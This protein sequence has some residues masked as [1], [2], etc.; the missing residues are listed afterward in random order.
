MG[1]LVCA[2]LLTLVVPKFQNLLSDFTGAQ[3]TLPW[4]TEAIFALSA[5]MQSSIGWLSL[6]AILALGLYLFKKQSSAIRIKAALLKIP[7]IGRLEH[8][9]SS[10]VLL[11]SLSLLLSNTIPIQS[12]LS[13]LERAFEKHRLGPTIK[14]LKASVNEGQSISYSLAL[15]HI[16]T[17]DSRHMIQSGELSAQLPESLLHASEHLQ[18][19]LE[20]RLNILQKL[21]EPILIT[22]LAIFVALLIFALL[23]PMTQVIETLSSF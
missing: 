12:A 5:A 2:I 6:A 17:E 16:G 19:E 9:Y 18:E 7:F 3:T 11:Q 10:T 1:L 14:T 21:T 15:A 4:L 8:M 23:L 22:L 20:Q 13:T